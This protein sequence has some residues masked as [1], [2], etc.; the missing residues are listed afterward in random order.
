MCTG[1]R[2]WTST[3]QYTFGIET[4]GLCAKRL[5]T[6]P[7]ARHLPPT[8]SGEGLNCFKTELKVGIPTCGN[9][10][11]PKEKGSPRHSSQSFVT[12]QQ[13]RLSSGPTHVL[14]ERDSGSRCALCCL[15]EC[16]GTNRQERRGQ[17]WRVC[18]CHGTGVWRLGLDPQTQ[19]QPGLLPPLA[20]PRGHRG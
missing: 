12:A 10:A 1:G 15:G 17:G 5:G 7:S 19:G 18:V 9:Q 4:S 11:K 3:R 16:P 8:D 14:Q 13:S 20:P 6:Q 2:I